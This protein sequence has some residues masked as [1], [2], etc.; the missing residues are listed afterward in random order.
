MPGFRLSKAAQ[1]DV[2][3]IA[4]YTQKEW[5]KAQRRR[6]L[7][8]LNDKFEILSRSP[9]ITAERPD[10]DPPVRIHS[11]EKHLIVYVIDHGGILIVRVLHQ[12]MDV[13]AHLSKSEGKI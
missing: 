12:S 6:Y 7:D 13:P 8:G 3:G 5:G 4:R 1:N 10:F 2:R 11:Y 9:T